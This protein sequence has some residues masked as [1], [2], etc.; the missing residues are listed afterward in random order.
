MYSSVTSCAMVGTDPRPVRIETT[1]TGGRHSF[2][3]VGLPDTAVRESRERVRAAIH[4]QGFHFPTGRVTVNLSPA[5]IPKLGVTYD[6]PIAMSIVAASMD[7]SDMFDPFVAVGE[8]TLDGTVRPVRAALGA[9]DVAA[10]EGKR[11]LLSDQTRLRIADPRQVAGIATLSEAVAVARGRSE[12]RTVEQPSTRPVHGA[13]LATVRGQDA[14]RRAL[15]V[16]AAGGHH[17]VM[18]GSP[19]A[20]KTLLARCLAG[21]LPDL[22]ESEEREV[23]LVWSTV[24]L[25]RPQPGQPPFRAPHHSSSLAALVGGG[26]GVPRPGEVSRAHRGVLFL[27][28]M[29]EFAPAVLDALRQPVEAGVITVARS[30]ETTTFPARIQVM[31]A[32]NPCPCGYAGDHRRPCVCSDAALGRYVRRLSGPLI[33]RF[34]LRVDVPR[35][36]GSEITGPAGEPSSAVRERVSAARRVQRDRGTLNRDLSGSDLAALPTSRRAD[37]RLALLA[38]DDI[39]ARGWDR[40]RRVARTI[41]DLAGSNLVDADHV[42]EAFSFRGAW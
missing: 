13:D 8:L 23:A 40:I 6:L 28:E 11:C 9:L 3:I 39:T 27:D 15:E 26:V 35:L 33:D 22:T 12:G 42:D 41:A 31:G 20:G 38:N 10:R 7:R 19:G 17:M 29:G 16:A 24:G 30:A 36:S 5:D 1:A 25:D 14:T 34:D 37:E 18:R 2:H 4:H 32:T 21:I